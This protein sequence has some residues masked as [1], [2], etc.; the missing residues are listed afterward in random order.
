MW[1]DACVHAQPC[2][3]R[4]S[5]CTSSTVTARDA[6]NCTSQINVTDLKLWGQ[7]AIDRLMFAKCPRVWRTSA[8]DQGIE[9]FAA[10]PGRRRATTKTTYGTVDEECAS[11]AT[12]HSCVPLMCTSI[13]HLARSMPLVCVNRKLDNVL[14]VSNSSR[15]RA[16]KMGWT[17]GCYT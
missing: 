1:C 2:C 4:V 10:S 15:N 6:Q 16:D 11:A 13:R 8:N 17:Y 9:L 7:R 5:C 3:V 14:F 12:C